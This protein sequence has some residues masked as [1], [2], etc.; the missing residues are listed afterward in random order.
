MLPTRFRRPRLEPTSVSF[1]SDIDQ[2]FD[3]MMQAWR[4]RDQDWGWADNETAAYLCD[5]REENGRILVDAELPGFTREEVKVTLEKGVLS[6]TA[7]HKEE[8]KKDENGRSF[9][10]E[11]RYRRIQRSFTLPAAVNE[12]KVDANLKDGVLHLALEKSKESM[13]HEIAIK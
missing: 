8:K 9:L 7:E 13:P 6:I 3:N 12:S 4:D 10:Q 2:V 11:R 5:I 1:P